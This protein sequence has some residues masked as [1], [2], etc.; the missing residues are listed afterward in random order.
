MDMLEGLKQNV[1]LKDYST[2][3]LGGVAKYLCELQDYHEL[4]TIIE[5]A[6]SQ[7][8]PVMMIGGGSNIIW[9]DEGYEGVVIVNRIP[10]FDIQDQGEQQFAIVGAGENWDEVV[11]RTVDAGLSGL[12][13]LS[14]IPGTAGATPI[15]NVGAYGREV[16]DVLVCVQ[17]YDKQ[18]KQM[19]VLPKSDCGFSYRSSRFK[20][21]DRG[22][23]FITSLTFTLLKKAPS[24]PFYA[25][26]DAYFRKI[27]VS[28][29]EVTS[30]ILR[31]AVIAIRSE[32]LPDPAKVANCGS[33]FHNPIIPMMQLEEIREQYP[34]VVYWSV[35]DDQAK[36]AAGWL[37]EQLGL[38]GYHEPN[39][40]IAVWDKQALVFVNESA[41]T[42]AQLLAF[43]DA[44]LKAVKDK[45]GIELAQE[46]ELLP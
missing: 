21:K 27:G 26:L 30:K 6:E 13:Q 1:S 31:D 42:T 11:E 2:M 46:P 14:L 37:L 34:G 35:G 4:P 23:F 17:A 33:F 24:P 16:A 25:A 29:K 9:R 22:R 41:Q 40:G 28:P 19:V 10:G 44:V 36:V 38:K 3:R 18:T 12:E 8:L 5:W 20:E 15:Q 39:T 45:F 43:R 7:N 32:K